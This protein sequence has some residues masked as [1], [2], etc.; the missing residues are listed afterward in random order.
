VDEWWDKKMTTKPHVKEWQAAVLEKAEK[1]DRWL[2]AEDF[3][4]KNESSNWN[5]NEF[6][7][8]QRNNRYM[9]SR[10]EQMRERIRFEEE[11]KRQ[12]EKERK[13]QETQKALE[14]TITNF[15]TLSNAPTKV[16]APVQFEGGNFAQKAAEWKEK[17]TLDKMRAAVE[18]E[19]PRAPSFY[20]PQR[21]YKKR[22]FKGVSM[23]DDFDVNI[24]REPEEETT[25]QVED[26][27]WETVDRRKVHAYKPRTEQLQM[28][29]TVQQR[30]QQKK[31]ILQRFERGE[32]LNWKD[33]KILE[34]PI[35][36]DE[37]FNADLTT[38]NKTNKNNQRSNKNQIGTT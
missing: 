1:E 6:S 25:T 17:D 23:N 21:S 10:K 28:S 26:E 36:D 38:G 5:T 14:Q 22:G 11:R 13:E 18:E 9:N 19:A 32:I 31:E 27:G 2:T 33:R 35:E 29:I 12:E 30:I 24:Y 8:E 4:P 16:S 3:Y 15:P 7:M 34:E 37:E 20:T